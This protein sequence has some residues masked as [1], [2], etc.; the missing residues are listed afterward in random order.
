[1]K[2][3]CSFKI[4]KIKINWSLTSKVFFIKGESTGIRGSFMLS[5]CFQIE[6]NPTEPKYQSL[7]ATSELIVKFK[8]ERF[9][10]Y[11]LPEE[12]RFNS[13]S[14]KLFSYNFLKIIKKRTNRIMRRKCADYDKKYSD[15][16]SK[17]NCIDR[18]VN[19]RFIETYKSYTIY[20]IIDKDYFTKDQWSNSL[21]NN[22]FI[23]FKKTK[24]ECEKEFKDD[25]FKV[26]FKDDKTTSFNY[27]FKI[28]QIPLYYNVITEIEEEASLYKLLMD[29]LTMQSVLFGQNIFELLLIIYCLLNTK[30][31]LRNNKYYFLFN[32]FNLF[33]RIYL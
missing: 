13:E 33:N 19:K 3:T 10:L 27:D 31:Q 24:Q 23:I 30:Y 25:C 18:C 12:E 8:I 6:A 32:L 15:C 1:M 22:K 2:S 17:Q 26:K 5:R 4:K 21:P 11:L 14:Y 9:D 7:L 28:M 29:V 20:S 16:N